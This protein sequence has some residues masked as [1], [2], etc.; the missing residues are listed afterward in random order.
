MGKGFNTY[1]PS[2]I[3]LFIKNSKK[4]TGPGRDF[5]PL[6]LLVP[7]RHQVRDL[8]AP[9]ELRQQRDEEG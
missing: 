4:N 8:V 6:A 9:V 1:K 2:A 5:P 7:L 3:C